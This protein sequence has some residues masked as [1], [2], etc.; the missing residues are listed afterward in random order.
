MTEREGGSRYDAERRCL[1]KRCRRG[2]IR[3]SESR[4]VDGYIGGVGRQSGV[5]FSGVV[6][7]GVRRYQITVADILTRLLEA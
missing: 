6:P 3:A 1:G 4:G 5:A 2:G 7:K